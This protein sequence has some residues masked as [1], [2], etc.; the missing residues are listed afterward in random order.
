M[1]WHFSFSFQ[2]LALIEV[3]VLNVHELKPLRGWIYTCEKGVEEEEEGDQKHCTSQ[4]FYYW[5][6]VDKYVS[7]FS[8]NIFMLFE[9]G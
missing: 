6:C 9:Y 7:S 2:K 3:L 5:G 8:S 1:Q 4:S